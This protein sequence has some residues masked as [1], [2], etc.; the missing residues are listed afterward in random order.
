M[1]V[2]TIKMAVIGSVLTAGAV[3][4]FGLP[5]AAVASASIGGPKCSHWHVS[6]VRPGTPRPQGDKIECD[7]HAKDG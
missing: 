4:A 6:T 1:K 2:R 7:I 5:A 3:A